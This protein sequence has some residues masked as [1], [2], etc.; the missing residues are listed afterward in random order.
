MN[1]KRSQMIE[2][3]ETMLVETSIAPQDKQRN[4]T[5]IARMLERVMHATAKS[6]E[7]YED[8]STIRCRVKEICVRIFW[9]KLRRREQDSDRKVTLRPSIFAGITMKQQQI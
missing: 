4:V 2:K 3:L 7:E 8:E 6:D 1:P 5:A 9:R